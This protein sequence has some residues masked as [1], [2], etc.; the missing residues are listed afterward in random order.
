MNQNGRLGSAARQRTRLLNR[1]IKAPELIQ[2]T[3]YSPDS[4]VFHGPLRDKNSLNVRLLPGGELSEDE[5]DGDITP[6]V[7]QLD[8]VRELDEDK[9]AKELVNRYFSIKFFI[10]QNPVNR[11]INEIAFQLDLY[12]IFSNNALA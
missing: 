4:D 10:L 11:T 8:S 5:E 9:E 7:H 2:N 3:D 6:K 1:D 12:L